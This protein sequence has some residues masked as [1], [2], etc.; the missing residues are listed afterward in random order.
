MSANP[1]AAVTMLEPHIGALC[2][3]SFPAIVSAWV[4]VA[5]THQVWLLLLPLTCVPGGAAIYPCHATV[6]ECPATV[7]P[8]E[9]ASTVREVYYMVRGV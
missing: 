8:A 7:T 1:S 3:L 4:T 9:Q 5:D 6:H 2:M